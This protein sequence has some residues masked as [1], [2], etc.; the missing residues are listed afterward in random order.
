MCGL[1]I[2]GV[3]VFDGEFLLFLPLLSLLLFTLGT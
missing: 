3:F 1:L 2:E